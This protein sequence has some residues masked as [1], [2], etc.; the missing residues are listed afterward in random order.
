MRRLA[1]L[2]LKGRARVS[3]DDGGAL[4]HDTVS[5]FAMLPTPPQTLGGNS[6]PISFTLTATECAFLRKHLLGVRRP[7]TT[8]PS[9]LAR[10][11]EVPVAPGA[12]YPW[13]REIVEIADEDDKFAL[14]VA[15]KAAALAGIGRGIYAA[16]TELVRTKD[17]L[18][19]TTKQRDHLR[20]MVDSYGDDARA[21]ELAKLD[22]LIPNLSGHLKAVLS[23][24]QNWLKAKQTDLT[25]L[26]SVYATAEQARK[27]LRA[28][29]PDNVAGQQRRV[30]WDPELQPLGRPLGYRWS[31]VRRLMTDLQA[32]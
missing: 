31:N 12:A 8:K 28:R 22:A 30:E 20:T 4:E 1:Q 9:L 10:L 27:G 19:D 26:R 11:A 29:L 24:T 17:G 23:A 7:A 3:D 15:R 6:E 25:E 16:L 5:P 21:L 13:S 32:S 2:R 18:P 14:T